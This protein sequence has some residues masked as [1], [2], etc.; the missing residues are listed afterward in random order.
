MNKTTF[1]TRSLNLLLLLLSGDLHPIHFL[2]RNKALKIFHQNICGLSGKFDEL[3]DILLHYKNV[4]IF[5]LTELFVTD[6][7]KTNSDIQGYIFLQKKRK[8][9]PAVL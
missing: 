7:N 6:S 4:D 2:K 8:V 9:E 3:R 5:D 1:N